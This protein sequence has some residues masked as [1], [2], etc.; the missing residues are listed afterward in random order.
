MRTLY[1][2]DDDSVE[3]ALEVQVMLAERPRAEP[4]HCPT[5][6]LPRWLLADPVG[7]RSHAKFLGL[8]PVKTGVEGMIVASID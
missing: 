1:V 8:G 6:L 4:C 2:V 3:Q 7:E 5:C